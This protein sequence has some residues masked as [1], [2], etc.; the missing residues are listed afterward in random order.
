MRF[1]NLVV[2]DPAGLV[3]KPTA[4]GLGFTNSAGGSTFTS[5][6]PQGNNLPGSL[7]IEF[8]FAQYTFDQYQGTALIHVW[9]VGLGM[10]SQAANLNGSDF[11]LYAGMMQGLPLAT[12]AYQNGQQGLILQGRIFQAFG[13]W[14]GVNQTLDLL[15][16]PG[17]SNTGQDIGFNWPQGVT[18]TGAL[19]Q[20]MQQAF[21]T[22]TVNVNVSDALQPKSAQVGHY[23]SLAAFAS[24]L[25]AHTQSLGAGTYGATYNGVTITIT[26]KTI[27]ITDGQGPTAPKTITLN[28]QDLIGQPTW[29]SGNQL[30]FK[31]VLRAD[32]TVGTQV[33]FPVGLQNP[34]ALTSAEAAAA[35]PGLAPASSKSAF[36][37]TF[38]VQE[39]HYFANFRQADA[40]SWATAFV[41][42]AIAGTATQ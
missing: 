7:N 22:Y 18:L 5:Q 2:T 38:F 19:Q 32:I 8:D 26:N 35:S 16:Y 23:S 42:A 28:F 34:Y 24:Y 30:S 12:A 1:Y 37:G 36:T 27:T 41:C 14:Q 17:A 29:I 6:D 15:C 3:W 21:P 33:K 25:K 40:D 9:G 31:T 13:N 20:T 11:K 10:I 4:D 39:A